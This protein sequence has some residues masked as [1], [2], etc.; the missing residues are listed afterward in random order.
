MKFI[1]ILFCGLSTLCFGVNITN[2]SFQQTN[3]VQYEKAQAVFTLSQTY[4]NPYNPTEITVDAI[5]NLPDGTTAT[6]PCFYYV[7]STISG[8]SATQ[9][10]AQATWML[11]YAPAKVG[12]YTFKIKVQDASG[13]FYSTNVSI[14][15]TSGTKKGFV[16]LHPTNKQFMKFDNGT[17]YYPVG[18]NLCWNDGNLLDFYKPYIDSLAANGASWTRYWMTDF[19]RQALEWSS[20]HWSGWY[21]GLGTYSQ[22]AASIL[23]SV[24]TMCD[25]KEIYMQ[26]VLQHHGQF[27]TTVNPEWYENPYYV[28]KGGMLNKASE[29]F[30]NAAAK[31]QT[32]KLYRYII[33]RWGYSTKILSWELFN[34]V[35]FTEG[36][37]AEIDTWHDEMSQYLKQLDVNQHL[38]TTSSGKD[39]ATLPLMN[40]NAAMDQLQFH[41]YASNIET[42][43]YNTAQSLRSSL[44]KP[45]LCGEFGTNDDYNNHPDAWNDHVRK[46]EWIGMFSETPN[47]FW[48]W[49][50]NRKFYNSFK[51]LSQFLNGI[52]LVAETGGHAMTFP[53]TANAGTA[54]TIHAIPELDWAT[55]T[56]NDFTVDSN[57]N[58]SGLNRKSKYL[59]GVWQVAMGS[60]TSFTVNY[61]TAGTALIEISNIST[62]NGSEKVQISIDGAS[63]GTQTF[64][65]AGT[66]SVNVPAGTHV[67]RYAVTTNDWV[68][69]VRYSFTSQFN[70]LTAYG[71]RGSNKAYGYITDKNYGQWA[72]STS[73]NAIT[74]AT[75]RINGL[76]SG[77]YQVQW[78]NPQ[79]GNT[80]TTLG[81]TA[82]NN[83]INIALPAF[84]KDLAFKISPQLGVSIPDFEAVAKPKGRIAPNP[85]QSEFHLVGDVD[86]PVLLELYD[87]VGRKVLTKM[88]VDETQ[89][90]DIQ[91]FTTGVY[92]YNWIDKDHTRF[93]GKVKIE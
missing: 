50:S 41:Q 55:S 31:T 6:V 23:D 93:T 13:T 1:T 78:M 46:S 69:V 57:N 7:P 25:K 90:I 61:P 92:F 2:F 70:A 64:T 24:L 82:V 71:Y 30:N 14:T 5:V 83:A 22:N 67:I 27:S 8:N 63:V 72:D 49:Q 68:K 19:A 34:E 4:S 10:V 53:V 86:Y 15:V 76:L 28:N 29:F 47:L 45:I 16:R 80:T 60:Y 35:E 32:K 37:N 87:M 88:V 85:A 51:P 65:G 73:M 56:Q 33:A 3:Y 75:L 39:N 36:T 62:V 52:D 54:T 18:M 9:N 58:I 48:Y 43:L 59:Q 17:P 81:F 12:N 77:N 89:S 21:N 11:R 20:S 74:G 38:V 42:Q 91:H 66:F 26:L 84:K 79:T 40:D 44:T